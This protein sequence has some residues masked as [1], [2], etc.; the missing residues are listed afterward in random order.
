MGPPGAGKGTQAAVLARDLGLAH[1]ATGD[2]LRN[3]TAAGSPV[4]LKAKTFMEAGR[5]VPDDVMTQ[6]VGEY[7]VKA[8]KANGFVLDGYPRTLPQADALQ[9]LLEGAS[10]VLTAVVNLEVP[11]E[12]I[13]ARL[14][15]RQTCPKDQR[16]Y[17]PVNNPPGKPGVCDACGSAL[18]TRNDD[19]EAVVRNRL[20]V[21]REST[22]PLVEFY[23]KQGLLKS[24]DGLAAIPKI[25]LAIKGILDEAQ[26][27]GPDSGRGTGR[28]ETP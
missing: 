14:A 16:T 18:V 28:G 20:R 17:H 26:T 4:G 24:V 1:L 5:L 15:N 22:A 6:L 8:A 25:V 19:S 11:E 9:A 13:V 23:K 27:A 12:V 2:I 10:I 7:V 21:Y 3:E